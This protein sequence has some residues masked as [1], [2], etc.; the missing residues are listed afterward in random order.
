MLQAIV[1]ILLVFMG[2][3]GVLCIIGATYNLYKE[4][5]VYCKHPEIYRN[6]MVMESEYLHKTRKSNCDGGGGPG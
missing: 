3:C 4:L 1:S 2:I 6:Y 5:F